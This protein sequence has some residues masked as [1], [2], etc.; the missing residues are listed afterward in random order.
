M[1]PCQAP[2]PSGPLEFNRSIC[3]QGNRLPNARW[4]ISVKRSHVCCCVAQWI[5]LHS[6][7]ESRSLDHAF[8][9]IATG[10]YFGGFSLA[11]LGERFFSSFVLFSSRLELGKWNIYYFAG[12]FVFCSF[13]I[14]LFWFFFLFR[15]PFLV[16]LVGLRANRVLLATVSW[17]VKVLYE[18]LITRIKVATRKV[19]L[20][21]MAKVKL[22]FDSAPLGKEKYVI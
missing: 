7:I 17:K 3:R 14:W 22:F 13:F 21:R 5:G 12:R 8:V 16:V 4:P 2:I 19:Y 10:S 18:T 11:V 15:L 9:P 6:L 20:L 1:R